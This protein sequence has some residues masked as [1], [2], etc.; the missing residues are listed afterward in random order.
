MSELSINDALRRSRL[1]RELSDDEVRVLADHLVFRDLKPGDVL[2]AEGT[3]DNH[4]YVIVH[5]AL[6]VVRSHGKSESTTLF[7]LGA[8]D[9][10]GEMSFLDETPHYAAL[11]SIGE[12][13]V[14]GL[15]REKLEEL[16]LAHPRLVYRVMRAIIRTVHEVQR[17][18][19]MHSV[20]LANY[21]YKQH[22][23][24]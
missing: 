16:L 12:T 23:R 14:F 7:T 17:R 24:Y 2:V 3:S 15:E 20:E 8:G 9:L 10:V 6:G 13:R 21:I 11:V 4:L 19:S 22:G 1:A 18:I 5:G